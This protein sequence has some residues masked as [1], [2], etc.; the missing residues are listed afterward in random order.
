M[1]AVAAESAVASLWRIPLLFGEESFNRQEL[2][3]S[4]TQELKKNQKSRAEV[5][6]A[7]F[8]AFLSTRVLECWSSFILKSFLTRNE[9][10]DS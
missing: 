2:K 5:R 1:Q 9:L 8:F 4:R 10:V 7:A 3:H 6:I